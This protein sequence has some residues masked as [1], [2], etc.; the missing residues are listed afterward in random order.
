[1]N[2]ASR[3][4]VV[5][6]T[7]GTGLAAATLLREADVPVTA[8]VRSGSDASGL[9]SCGCQVVRGDALD[10]ESVDQAM[11]AGPYTAMVLSLG[12]K[13]GEPRPD[14]E[15]AVNLV[16][17]ARARG[18]TRIV[19]V[20]AIGC[21]DSRDVLHP[22]AWEFLGPVIEL[23]DQSETFLQSSG[24]EW[25]IIRP[26]GMTSDAATGQ[27]AL[28]EDHTAMGIITRADLGRLVVECLNNDETVGQIYHAVDPSIKRQPPLQR[29]EDIGP[30]ESRYGG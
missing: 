24:L 30:P 3:V 5:G 27:G 28:T 17:A 20:T 23:K 16:D 1:M 15:G 26:G 10:R 11:D 7:R 8:L 18:L 6:G 22:K 2:N 12:G 14:L 4:L 9:E 19:M 25:T 21:G 13:R 29:G